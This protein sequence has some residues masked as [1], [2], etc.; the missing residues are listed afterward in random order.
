[1]TKVFTTNI[2]NKSVMSTDGDNI[3]MLSNI[4]IDL[5]SGELIDLVVKPDMEADRSGYRTEEDFVFIPFESVRAIKDYV[6]VDK[7]AV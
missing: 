3:G 1:M 5:R 7:K 2:V 4:V 6:V